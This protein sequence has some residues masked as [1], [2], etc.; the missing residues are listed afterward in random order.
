MLSLD[1]RGRWGPIEELRLTPICGGLYEK[2]PHI[3][4]FV[5]RQQGT[6]SLG[7]D[8]VMPPIVIASSDT[9]SAVRIMVG[10]LAHIPKHSPLSAPVSPSPNA[11]VPPAMAM[12]I[13]EDPR[14]PTLE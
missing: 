14:G 1:L 9:C 10:M 8:P 4:W 3:D 13:F 6:E 11:G 2:R 7:H 12:F 5:G